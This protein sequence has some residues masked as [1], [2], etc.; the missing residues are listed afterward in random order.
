MIRNA[1][2][3][4]GDKIACTLGEQR[5]TFHQLD[6]ESNR[7][8]HMLRGM[9]VGPRRPGRLVGRHFARGHA[10]IRRVGEAR[11]SV[12]AGQ[13]PLRRERGRHRRGLC[14]PAARGRRRR[15][16]AELT[17]E[18]SIAPVI[19]A[20]RAVPSGRARRRARVHTPGLD[21]RDPHVMFFTSGSTG[22]P[23]GVVL[24]HRANY[25]RASP[26]RSPVPRPAWCA[27]SRCSTWPDGAW[28]SPHGARTAPCTTRRPD[29]DSVLRAVERNRATELYCIPAVWARLLQ[30]D[31][32]G[33]DLTSLRTADTGT[34][35]TPPELV[36]AIRDAFPETI[37]RVVVRL[38][39]GRPRNEAP[40]RGPA[41]EAGQ[42]RA[43]AAGR[44]AEARA[45]ARCACGAR[46]SW[47]GTSSSPTPRR[48]AARRLVPHR[49]PGR[50]STTRATCRSSGR[51]REV[52]RTGGETVA[53]GEVEAA[54][55][56]HP[57][58]AEVAVVGV[59]DAEWGEVVC[60]VVVLRHGST[61]V[62]DLDTLRAHCDG[63]A[64]SLQTPP[65]PRGRRASSRAPRRP[66][67]CSAPCSSNGSSRVE[68][69][70]SDGRG[71]ERTVPYR[72]I[73]A[74]PGL[75]GHDRGVKVIARALRDAGFEVIYL[76][77]QQTPAGIAEAA[78]QED[79]DAVGLSV[80][81]GAHL[82]L[83]QRTV[84]ELHARPRSRARVRRRDHPRRRPAGARS[85]RCVEAVHSGRAA[86]R[87]HQLVA[88]R[89][90]RRA[91]R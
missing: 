60:A 85:S 10:G 78:L 63:Q 17:E 69:G 32:S 24:S 33:Y 50:R 54:L 65:P 58:I 34:S 19:T 86:R 57:S 90:R 43:A 7:V 46:T 13:R 29:A 4:A 68:N 72:V 16:R 18:W 79:V 12:R 42:R 74:K 6:V 71:A 39:R 44:V 5:L 1:A 26:V 73:V 20:L 80:L 56:D 47:T 67:R 53:P 41:A 62:L 52:L 9:G 61:A 51:A 55:A 49:R 76:G 14:A 64:R 88:R 81:S 8:A 22:R 36:D 31:R 38:D 35:A 30:H 87:D 2:A 77:L 15:P 27:C 28:R 75:D 66:G 40:P 21:E 25:L 91:D 3:A 84:D 59:P 82:T 48:G 37:T 45:T 11:G 70:A 23:K 89:A 83:F